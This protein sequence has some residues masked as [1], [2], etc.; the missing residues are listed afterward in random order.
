MT[1]SDPPRILVIRRRYLG[2]IVLLAP[3]LRNLRLH[4]PRA[5]LTV[6]TEERFADILSLNS[7]VDAVLPYPSRGLGRQLA[8]WR[9]LRRE[10]FTHVFDLDCND[11]SALVTAL[12]GAA[13]RSVLQMRTRF[14][15][16]YN[17]P[18]P[19]DR[20]AYETSHITETTLGLLAG[21]QIPVV[22][23]EAKLEPRAED[24]AAM[25]RIVGAAGP[26]LLVHPGSRSAFRLWP[27]ERFAAI[28]DRAQDELAAQVVLVGGP[29]EAAL[30]AEI[31][32]R[33]QS[34]LLALAEPLSLPRLAALIRL[35]ATLLC[36]DSGPM[37]VAAAVGTPVVALFGS[38]NAVMWRPLGPRHLVLQPPLPCRSCI[39]PDKCVPGDSYRNY[40]VKNIDVDTVWQ[41]LRQRFNPSP[42]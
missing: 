6:L 42:N 35:S 41:A 24:L 9:A 14:G 4:W 38:Q 28:C 7:D 12:S 30:I 3:L 5:R 40:C 23:H 11:R 16:V 21:Q 15:W 17:R 39:A 27:A 13:V 25:S 8:F 26:V 19:V 1:A 29:G 10:K 2:D 20:S 37:H 33:A 34:H 32:R 36:H 18:V 31:R 22:S